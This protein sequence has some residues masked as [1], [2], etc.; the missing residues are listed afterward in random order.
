MSTRI[1]SLKF[2][3]LPARFF[4]NYDLTFLSMLLQGPE[5]CPQI[6]RR[7]CAASPLRK[8]NCCSQTDSLAAAADASIILGWWKL[9]DGAAD[10]G[11]FRGLPYRAAALFFKP[12]MH[13]AAK[14]RP[15]FAQKTEEL[16][17]EL[18]GIESRRLASIDAPADCFGRMLEALAAF[19]PEEDVQPLRQLLYHVGRWIYI[20]DA[21][22]DIK[23]DLRLGGYNPLLLRFGEENGGLSESD[24]E[25]V[26][27]TLK[28]SA[29]IAASAY[30]LMRKN[31]WTGLVSNIIYLG[32]PQTAEK[33]LAGTWRETA[34]EK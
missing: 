14:R 8:K 6:E 19:A 10:K 33:V 32:L 18:G 13:R 34:K 22:D 15:D 7:R 28:H 31:E 23:E 25:Y 2:L 1:G 12:A 9:R 4:V 20:V 24:R 11:F 16:L 26:S 3:I 27:V 21:Y 17:R 5:E 29:A 30:E